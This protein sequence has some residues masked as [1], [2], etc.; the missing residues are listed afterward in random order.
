MN[1]READAGDTDG[2]AALVRKCCAMRASCDP[3]RYELAADVIR[4]YRL[5]FGHVAE[6]PRSILLVAEE[7]EAIVGF[8]IAVVNREMPI[9][10]L[11][12][13][14]LIQEMWVEPEYDPAGAGASLVAKAGGLFGEMGIRQIRIEAPAA[15]ARLRK[16]LESA[17][18]RVCSIDLLMDLPPRRSRKRSQPKPAA[19]DATDVGGPTPQ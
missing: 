13:Y 19:T 12:E 4:E 1:I 6:D 11:A 5:W 7:N 14:A 17:G 16:T 9:Y 3:A 10:K 8:L 2:I 18:F 15:D